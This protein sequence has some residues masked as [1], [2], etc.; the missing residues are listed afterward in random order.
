MTR[1]LHLAPVCLVLALHSAVSCTRAAPPRE[2]TPTPVVTAAPAVASDPSEGATATASPTAEPE[3]AV[4]PWV[5]SWPRP[6]AKPPT[7]EELARAEESKRKTEAYM[8]EY[9]AKREAEAEVARLAEEER[10]AANAAVGLNCFGKRARYTCDEDEAARRL[11]LVDERGDPLDERFRDKLLCLEK[12]LYGCEDLKGREVVPFIHSQN[13]G[14]GPFKFGR[15]GF[16]LAAEY[17]LPQGRNYYYYYINTTYTKRFKAETVE[18]IPDIWLFDEETREPLTIGRYTV[19]GLTGFLDV[20]RGIL[21]PP[22]FEA[23]SPFWSN[24]QEKTLVCEGCHPGRSGPCPPPQ[25]DCRGEA[26]FIDRNGKRLP[27]LPDRD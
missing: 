26:Y 12:E 11:V 7:A 27:E 17:E 2:P 3:E 4:E 20:D 6:E 19:G 10:V 9:N 14:V 1:P 15:A 24:S 23:V 13:F 25:P 18:A 16:A 8:K 21:T 5:S 22:K